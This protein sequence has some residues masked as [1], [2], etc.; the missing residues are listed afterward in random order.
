MATFIPSSYVVASS[1][2][3]VVTAL[4][5]HGDAAR[6]I[7]GGTTI[8]E[9]AEHGLMLGVTHLID[10]TEIG[11]SFV[12]TSETEIRVGATTT[13]TDLLSTFCSEYP[14]EFA[15]LIEAIRAI[16]PRQV[17]NVATVGGSLCS[18]LPFFD[19]P[20]ALLALD[21]RIRLTGP[22]GEREVPIG[23]FFLDYFTPDLAGPELLAEVILARQGPQRRGSF[24]KFEINSV[25]WALASVAVTFDLHED[26]LSDVRIALGGPVGPKIV[27]ARGIEEALEGIPVRRETI[28]R[29]TERIDDD[30]AP[31]TDF[32][33]SSTYRKW[34][35]RTYIRRC[36][37]SAAGISEA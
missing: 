37:M 18:S 17:R 5:H 30:V 16:R 22:A 24:L 8:H 34:I 23:S 31:R 21:A 36:I 1:V 25:D 4:A 29:A 9:L 3:E 13:F 26:R 10:I 28:D 27:R 14:Q 6:V 32:R 19:L 11:L 20:P 15:V 33:A 35:Y 7:A 2:D 12:D